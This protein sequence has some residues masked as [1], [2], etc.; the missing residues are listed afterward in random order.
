MKKSL[1]IFTL[2]SALV[3]GQQNDRNFA[4]ELKGNTFNGIG[5]NFLA[6][7]AKTFAGFGLG[8]NGI[9]TRKIGLGLDFNKSY[10]QVKDISVYGDLRNPELTTLDLFAFYRHPFSEKFE[11]EGQIGGGFFGIKSRSDYASREFKENGSGFLIGA[12]ALYGL[13]AANNLFVVGGPRLYFASTNVDISDSKADKY[14][15]EPALLNFTLGL[16]IYF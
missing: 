15:S 13:N 8:V 4:V 12:K 9:V 16:R 2:F 5:D 11:L 3:F 14:Y 1:F 10:G 7:G 6:D